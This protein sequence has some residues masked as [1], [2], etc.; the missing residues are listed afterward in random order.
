MVE[1]EI[2]NWFPRVESLV[3]CERP[4]GYVV[5]GKRGDVISLLLK[6]GVKVY[7]FDRGGVLAVEASQVDDIIQGTE[8][9]IPP[10]RIAVS[11]QPAPAAGGARRLLGARWTS[12]RP[13][14]CRCCSSR[15]PTW[16]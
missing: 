5:P 4:L 14:W 3:T 2:T 8:D 15:S 9:Y 11:L 1:T 16:G 6:L 12:W 7:G 10:Q 13:T